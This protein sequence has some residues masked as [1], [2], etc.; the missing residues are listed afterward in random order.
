M[1][2]VPDIHPEMDV[3]VRTKTALAVPLDAEAQREKWKLY[4]AATSRPYPPGMAVED[5]TFVCAG[6]GNGGRI[7]TRVYRP[8]GARPGGP[9]IMYLHGGGFVKG[10]LESSDTVAWGIAAT[11]EATVV[12]VD[13]RLAPEHPFPAAT[14]DCYAAICYI[15]EHADELKV[16]ASRIATWGDS[17]GGNLSAVTCLMAKDRG[18]P[19]IA[20]QVLVYPCLT[21]DLSAPSYVANADSIGLT[22]QAMDFYWGQYLGD[23]SP[24]SDPYAA[25]LKATDLSGLPPAFVHIA[26]LDPLADDGRQYVEKLNAAGVTA[27]LRT[28]ER[29]I[30]GFLRARFEGPD[31]AAE[32]QAPCDFLTARFA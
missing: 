4:S 23:R 7:A 26:S 31:S 25:P 3:L 30:H 22:T 32:Y 6:A 14:E 29:M 9:C 21:D 17:A 28:A 27:E 10:S 1:T 15:A 5:K 18:G 19:A 11:L 2:Q 16:D 8:A 13:Y 12:S 20:G 24:T